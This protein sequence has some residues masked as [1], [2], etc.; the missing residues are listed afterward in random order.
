MLRPI[1]SKELLVNTAM[2]MN[3]PV[4]VVTLIAQE[5]WRDVREALSDLTQ[6]RVHVTCLGDF[7]I[8]HWKLEGTLEMLHNTKAKYPQKIDLDVYIE[9]LEKIKALM[10]EEQQRKE[11]IKTHKRFIHETK[12]TSKDMELPIPDLGRHKK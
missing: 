1:K 11:F 4:N 5:Y 7:T 6:D 12:I 3:L 2:E 9:K 8:K 10:N